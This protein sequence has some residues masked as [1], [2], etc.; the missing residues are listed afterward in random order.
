MDFQKEIFDVMFGL[1]ECNAYPETVISVQ[2]IL[3]KQIAM[4]FVQA[5]SIARIRASDE[6][7]VIDLVFILRKYKYTLNK[8]VHYY[9]QREGINSSHSENIETPADNERPFKKPKLSDCFSSDKISNDILPAVNNVSLDSSSNISCSK[10][11]VD[12]TDTEILNPYAVEKG[13]TIYHNI[14]DALK[15]LDIDLTDF[16]EQIVNAHNSWACKTVGAM[17]KCEPELSEH[18]QKCKSMSFYD[19]EFVKKILENM[20]CHISYEIYA[21]DILHFLAKETLS[22]LIFRIHQNRQ[23][24]KSTLGEPS[25]IEEIDNILAT[26][27]ENRITVDEVL[28][29]TNE[30][31]CPLYEKKE[32]VAMLPN[33]YFKGKF[34]LD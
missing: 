10:S 23:K 8:M 17:M 30:I 19:F 24:K 13:H 7:C 12:T 14:I 18:Y 31:W 11:T 9:K 34:I 5:E 21:Y 29:I 22:C 25:S 32:N 26:K 20:D 27:I 4:L 3:C 2:S 6:I 28:E 1:G 15:E 16:D 33:Y